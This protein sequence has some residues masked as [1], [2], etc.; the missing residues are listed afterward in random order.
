MT[1]FAAVYVLLLAATSLQEMRSYLVDQLSAMKDEDMKLDMQYFDGVHEANVRERLAEIEQIIKFNSTSRVYPPLYAFC[2]TG[3]VPERKTTNECK[4]FT[5]AFTKAGCCSEYH[6]AIRVPVLNTS[7][8]PAVKSCQ[9][10]HRIG[11]NMRNC[12][13]LSHVHLWGEVCEST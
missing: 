2:K 13:L 3:D 7:A 5:E 10:C 4:Q 9:T 6:A 12:N 1:S 8:I 11:R